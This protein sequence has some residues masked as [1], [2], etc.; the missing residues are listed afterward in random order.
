M[1]LLVLGAAVVQAACARLAPHYSTPSWSARFWNSSPI[2]TSQNLILITKLVLE[3]SAFL[4]QNPS[5]LNTL[6]CAASTMA[7]GGKASPSRPC[8]QPRRASH[9]ALVKLHGERP[10]YRGGVAP[11]PL[12]MRTLLQLLTCSRSASRTC[13]SCPADILCR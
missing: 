13:C 2:R 9:I 6:P 8:F 10:G 11:Q 3:T 12:R 4:G 7:A 5:Y 1:G